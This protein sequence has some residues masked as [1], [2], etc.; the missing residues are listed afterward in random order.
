MIDLDLLDARVALD[1]KNAL[2]LQQIV[3]ELLSSAD[4]E[5]RVRLAVEL[6]DFRQADSSRRM[7]REIARAETPAPLEAE[8]ARQ[9]PEHLRGVSEVVARIEGLRVV[10]N[11]GGVFD[12]VNIVPEPL[13]ADDVMN[14]LPDDAGDRHRAHE[15]HDDDALSFHGAEVEGRGENVQRST[16]NVQHSTKGRQNGASDS[17]VER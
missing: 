5:D 2:A 12:V 8:L 14:V 16:F 4:V 1:V 13:Q 15:A 9:L 3:V 7:V 10:G 6:L 11:P 17:S